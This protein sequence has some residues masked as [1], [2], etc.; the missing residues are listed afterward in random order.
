M[1]ARLTARVTLRTLGNYAAYKKQKERKKKKMEKLRNIFHGVRARFI[2]SSRP[3][4]RPEIIVFY[5]V[6]GGVMFLSRFLPRVVRG[7]RRGMN[8]FS[9]TKNTATTVRLSAENPQIQLK[10]PTIN[11]RN[12]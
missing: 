5:V 4:R 2:R 10:R 6:R 12:R 11:V 1:R 8:L 9:E 7:E 3:T